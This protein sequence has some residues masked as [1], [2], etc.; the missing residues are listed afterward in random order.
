MKKKIFVF[1][2]FIFSLNAFAK[3]FSSQQLIQSGHWVYDALSVL[4]SEQKLTSFA[5]N[6]PMTCAELK[7]YFSYI[8][9]N[10]L[11]DGSKK[12]Y[13]KVS[14]FLKIEILAL[15]GFKMFNFK[16]LI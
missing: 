5:V 13:D 15:I 8:D 7:L 1:F 2:S 10:L 12:I 14:D 6:A 4:N 16:R 11:S 9:Y 3:N